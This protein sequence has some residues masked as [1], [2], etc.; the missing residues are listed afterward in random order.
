MAKQ[1]P[2]ESETAKSLNYA[3]TEVYRVAESVDESI[4]MASARKEVFFL[5]ESV[6]KNKVNLVTSSRYC[7]RYSLLTK[8][9]LTPNPEVLMLY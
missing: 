8:V 6:F 4:D 3:L 1:F 5:Q 2:E 9:I 7:V